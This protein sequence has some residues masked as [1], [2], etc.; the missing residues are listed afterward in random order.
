MIM[1][2]DSSA[3][4][5]A[6]MLVTIMAVLLER[7]LALVFEQKF[8]QRILSG[9]GLK[10]IIAFGI[11]FFVCKEWAIDVVS[12]MLKVEPGKMLGFAI[13]AAAIAGGS[14]ASIKLFNDVIGIGKTRK[15]ADTNG[16]AK[17]S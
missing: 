14:K 17:S 8:V 4:F 2:I 1:Q 16:Q 5:D 3:I 10:E 11:C 9:K 6:F 15:D 13:T 7:S 12:M